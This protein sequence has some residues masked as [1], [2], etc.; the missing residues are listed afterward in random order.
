MLSNRT[1]L[2]IQVLF[3]L[4]GTD[5]RGLTVAELK[6]ES[7][8]NTMGI[9]SVVR[10]LTARGWILSDNRARLSLTPYGAARTLYDL[11]EVIH[12]EVVLGGHITYGSMPFW[13]AAAQKRIPQALEA[14]RELEREFGERL[15][16]ITIREL[17]TETVPDPQ[18][19]LALANTRGPA[20]ITTAG[21]RREGGGP[22][23]GKRP[24]GY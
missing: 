24:A 17:T 1:I 22:Q 9:S 6:R 10:Q 20:G 2:A 8:L 3:L 19:T 4:R 11:I 21:R 18:P 14:D 5:E 15:R 16:G 12:G 7:R 23:D 13:G